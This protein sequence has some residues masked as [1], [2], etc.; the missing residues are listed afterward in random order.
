MKNYLF[1][2]ISI[3]LLSCN[4]SEK[5]D[6][7]SNKE[8]F[9][10]A[11]VKD[12][13]IDKKE[14]NVE[15]HEKEYKASMYNNKYLLKVIPDTTKPKDNMNYKILLTLKTDTIINYIMNIDSINKNFYYNKNNVEGK[16]IN[17]KRDYYLSAINIEKYGARTH[18]LYLPAIVNSKIDSTK[19]N[20][21]LTFKYM[22][23]ET[24]TL[25]I[26]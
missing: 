26:Q 25:F 4:D 18:N 6:K 5:N 7:K 11:S 8:S 15:L 16:T 9:N 12:S 23:K 10:T 20:V 2:L 19:R 14:Y 17:F 24:G 3:M 21:S 22:G 1:F 13:I